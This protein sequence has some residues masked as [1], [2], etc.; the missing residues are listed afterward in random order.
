MQL[1][2]DANVVISMLIRPG[3]PLDM[4]LRSEI[5]VF[6]P[7][8]LFEEIVRNMAEIGEKSDLSED[9]LNSLLHD[10]RTM[11]SVVPEEDF[12]YQHEDARKI[13]PD[14]KDIAYFALAL[15]L[16]CSIWSNEKKLKEQKTVQIVSTHELMQLFP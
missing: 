3:K 4:L 2:I 8:L 9:E 12:L 11:I 14:P 1:V 13:C 5:E 7:S 15:H 10:L 16:R 6:T